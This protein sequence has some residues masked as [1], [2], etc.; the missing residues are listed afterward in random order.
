M[1]FPAGGR[2]PDGGENR[3]VPSLE[4]ILEA[5]QAAREAVAALR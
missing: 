3:A 1:T 5:D 4:R 2:G